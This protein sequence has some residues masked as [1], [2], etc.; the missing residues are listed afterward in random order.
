MRVFDCKECVDVKRKLPVITDHLCD[1]CRKHFDSLKEILAEIGIE[2]IEDPL[3][4][5]GLD[6]YT[7]TAFEIHHSELGA[8]SALCGGGRY[9]ELARD[10]GGGDI[11]AVGFSAGMERVIEALPQDSPVRRDLDRLDVYFVVLDEKSISTALKLA[12]SV[13]TAGLSAFVD[14][15]G[16]ALKKQLKSASSMGV[17]YSVIIGED[18]IERGEVALK[19]MTTSV[20]KS[21]PFDSLTEEIVKGE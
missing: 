13:R 15:S 6:Y 17:R 10:C 4:V 19:D 16:R 9:D 14:F 12:G 11:P 2:F 18:E 5:R 20:Q 8:Q 21:V 3:L 7:K 1:E